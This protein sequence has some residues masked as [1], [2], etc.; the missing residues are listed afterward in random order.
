MNH[1]AM[2]IVRPGDVIVVNGKGDLS[3][4]ST[5]ELVGCLDIAAL[6]GDPGFNRG[7]P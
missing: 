6:L 7:Q 4:Y 2:A 3:S 5:A 1:A